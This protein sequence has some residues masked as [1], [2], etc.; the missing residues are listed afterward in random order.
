MGDGVGHGRSGR[1]LLPWA[2]AVAAVAL[3]VVG[4]TMLR[5]EPGAAVVATAPAAAEGDPSGEA[6]TA[7]RSLPRETRAPYR[8]GSPRRLVIPAL[9][10]RNH[11]VP[12]RA[13]GGTLIPP[14]DPQQLGWWAQG[15]R[16]GASRGSALITG[17]TV[18]TG[19]GALDDLETL[20]RGDVV[21]VITDRGRIRYAVSSVEVFAKGTVAEKATGLFSQ[22]VSGRLVLITCEDW[23]GARYL[24]NTL[25][26][27]RP[28]RR[29][30]AA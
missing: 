8:P 30:P 19:G 27:A 2:L 7:V 20:R 29:A 17:H 21:T 16:P 10:V 4:A 18:H 1:A 15:A 13:P 9:G 25:V 5:H 26:T 11:V 23:D 28:S 22:R 3:V 14:S 6:A 24:S 12:V